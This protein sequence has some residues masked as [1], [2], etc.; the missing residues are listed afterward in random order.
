MKIYIKVGHNIGNVGKNVCTV[1]Q[2]YVKPNKHDPI[3]GVNYCNKCTG[4]KKSFKWWWATKIKMVHGWGKTNNEIIGFPFRN[5]MLSAE[6]QSF[7]RF[8]NL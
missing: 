2:I 1:L 8:L 6:V 4:K 7:V 3:F 5:I